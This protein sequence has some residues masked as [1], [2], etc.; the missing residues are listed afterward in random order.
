M[1]FHDPYLMGINTSLNYAIK[2]EKIMNTMKTENDMDQQCMISNSNHMIRLH[3]KDF[4]WMIR[5]K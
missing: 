5:W 1:S 4:Y 3:T 2:Y